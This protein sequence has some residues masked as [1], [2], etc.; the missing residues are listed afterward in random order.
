VTAVHSVARSVANS[1]GRWAAYLVDCL[2][3]M[4]VVVKVEMWAALRVALTVAY[5]VDH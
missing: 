4:T 5:S 3:V 2:D 1:V